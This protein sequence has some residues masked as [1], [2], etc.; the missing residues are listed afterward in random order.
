[1]VGSSREGLQRERE[2]ERESVCV[3]VCEETHSQQV[4]HV[5]VY[6][7]GTKISRIS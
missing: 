3:C 5:A 7:K 2:R 4:I 1:M 6:A